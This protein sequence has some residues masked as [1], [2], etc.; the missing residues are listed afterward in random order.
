LKAELCVEGARLLY[1]Y[2]DERGIRY[3]RCGKVI[4]ATQKHELPSLKELHR[5]A[6]A[7]GV[8][9]VEM[10][11]PQRLAELEPHVVGVGALHAPSTGIVDFSEV[12]RAFAKD[13]T[14]MGG[15]LRMA[16]E[17]TAIDRDHRDTVV[18]T[19]T[20]RLRARHLITCAGLH[21]D[22]L[23]R[24]TG[25]PVAPKII[26]FRGRYH[27]IVGA[28]RELIRALVY[29]VPNPQLPFLGAHFTKQLS[30]E[31]W[32][33]P[34]AILAL[35]REGYRG[36]DFSLKE[37][38]E[39]ATYRGFRLLAKQHWRAALA[40]IYAEVS[41]RAFVAALHRLVPD[42]RRD[43]V[44]RSHAGV[45]AQAVGEDGELLDD[46]WLD[47]GEDVTH[48]RNAPS[49]AATSCLALARSIADDALK[50]L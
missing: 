11:G 41:K 48:V 14:A 16:A 28:S 5:R 13:V 26:P 18:A 35:A 49:P 20:G 36:R 42:L 7:N 1:S 50:A 6:V 27:S 3:E 47:Q 31:V 44:V 32:A 24:M 9:G 22:R 19:S 40:E 25:A 8:E 46:F 10:I 12:T 37:L 43:D 2:C 4:V 45:R 29:P 23:A 15:Q 21:S 39:T 33:G 30:G 38:W 17:V 34:N